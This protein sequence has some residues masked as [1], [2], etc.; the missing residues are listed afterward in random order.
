MSTPYP[1]AARALLRDT[2]LDAA[3]DLLAQRPW[4]KVSMGEVAKRAGVSRQTL[5]NEIGGRPELAQAYVLREARLLLAA[6]EAVLGARPD[7]PRAA[8]AGAFERFL[9][10]AA[11]RPLVRAIVDDDGSDGLLALVTTQG[12]AVIGFAVD[13]LAAALTR[14]WPGLVN[15]DARRVADATVRLA[16]SHASRPAGPPAT[17]AADVAALLG[18][19]LDE[20]LAALP[21]AARRRA[22]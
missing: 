1:Q 12:G 5:Y 8:L 17:T 9:V 18:P 22:A 16:I 21:G 2:L 20:L 15:A 7:D 14:T 19:H 10:L 6:V 3:G 4:S 13:G 11:E